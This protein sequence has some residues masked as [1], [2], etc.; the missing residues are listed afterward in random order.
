MNYRI[1]IC[2]LLMI[3]NFK[4]FAMDKT[5]SDNDAMDQ[6]KLA[7]TIRS[8]SDMTEKMTSI[9]DVL[10]SSIKEAKDEQEKEKKISLQPYKDKVMSLR[11]WLEQV[12]R[13]YTKYLNEKLIDHEECLRKAYDNSKHSFEESRDTLY[14]E[15]L[16]SNAASKYIGHPC[17]SALMETAAQ[18]I[19]WIKT[20]EQ[21]NELKAKKLL[22]L[23]EL[24]SPSVKALHHMLESTQQK[25]AAKK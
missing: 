20:E 22:S 19:E 25:Y 17:S 4:I 1:L 24:L 13:C 11:C 12:S 2:T 6:K 8:T 16:S 9:M 10:V 21:N 15:F 7:Q 23:G 3:S 5:P 14:E 18:M